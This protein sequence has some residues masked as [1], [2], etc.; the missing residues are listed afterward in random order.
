MSPSSDIPFT[1]G[2]SEFTT[3]PL[4][5][6]EDVNLYSKLGVDTIEVCEF[7]LDRD[8]IDEQL[9]TIGRAG[10]KI[11]SAQPSTRT[12]FPS[13]SQP[14]PRSIDER[15]A[16]F[17]NTIRDFG[18]FAAGVP[19]VTNTGIPPSG[20]IQHLLE[21]AV[22]QYGALADYA[23]EHGASIALEPLN[24][25]IMNLESAIWTIEQALSLIEAVDRRNFGICMDF[26]N[27]W[28]NADVESWI[29]TC[30]DRIFVVQASDWRTPRSDQDR[31]IPGQGEIPTDA[32]MKAVRDA[33]FEGAYSVEIFSGNVPD[34][35]W[36]REPGEVIKESRDGLQRAWIA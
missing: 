9:A 8:R 12:L 18:P 14:E 5:F 36:K 24:A 16:R 25:S 35:L 20:N 7:K 23:Q 33:G 13:V 28:Q 26:W 27:V 32:L 22:R 4:T 30:G 6:E 31:L 34:S 29:R 19:F 10:L 3:W 11:S 17:R 15:M 21:V 1:F 2:V